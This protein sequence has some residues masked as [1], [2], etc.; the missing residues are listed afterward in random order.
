MVFF[1]GKKQKIETNN[2]NLYK[3]KLMQIYNDLKVNYPVIEKKRNYNTKPLDE[4]ILTI[5]SQ[6]TTDIN[7]NRAYKQLKTTYPD[8][9]SLLDISAD[10]LTPLI[11]PAG[12]QN[13]KSERILSVLK[14]IQ[15]ETGNLSLEFLMDYSN[16]EIIE[17][18]TSFK[19][20]GYKTAFVVMAFSLNR[21]VIPVDTHVLRVSKRL[22]LIPEKSTPYRAHI[23]L[24]QITPEGTALQTHLSLI[25][26]GRNICKAKKPECS[27]CFLSKYCNFYKNKL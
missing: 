8:L 17:Y 14:R 12:L 4:L 25:E 18:L 19:G 3:N 5:L 15:N 9:S 26:H 21:D 13:I 27:V 23:I 22:G 6:N 2:L 24:N 7:A 16:E 1:Q 11:K 10:Q 20:I